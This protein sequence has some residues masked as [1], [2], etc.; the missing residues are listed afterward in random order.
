MEKMVYFAMQEYAS[1]STGWFNG[2]PP[3]GGR[4]LLKETGKSS[5]FTSGV[6]TRRQT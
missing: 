5:L 2:T 6:R 4:V 3:T 1:N